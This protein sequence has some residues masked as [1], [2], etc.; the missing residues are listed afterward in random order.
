M[1]RNV[2]TDLVA[3]TFGLLL[4]FGFWFLLDPELTFLSI[5]FPRAMTA[6]MALVSALLVIKAFSKTVERTDL[7]TVGSN[8]RVFVTGLLFFGWA[9]SISYLGFFVAGVLAISLIAL[10]LALARRRVSV[11]VFAGWVLI[12]VVEVSFFY[13]VFTRLLHIPLPEG[14]FF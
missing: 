9:F 12:A 5:G 11:P 1:T 14:W 13:L 7:F 10:Y 3:G 2:N 4:S 8:L 6:I